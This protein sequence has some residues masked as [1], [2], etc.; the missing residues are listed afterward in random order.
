MADPTQDS[1]AGSA[2]A[3]PSQDPSDGSDQVSVTI[4]AVGDGTYTV[5]MSE[6][7]SDASAESG[8][9]PDD[10]PQTADNLD[11]A[12][13]IAAEMFQAESQ[14][15]DDDDGAD[16]NAPM[17]TGTAKSYWKQLAAKKS[18]ASASGGM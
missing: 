6:D 5:S 13:K 7:D 17:D 4:T 1:S 12:L 11:D 16:G 2:S 3:D 8:Q 14:E 9:D 15:G 18:K 10:Q